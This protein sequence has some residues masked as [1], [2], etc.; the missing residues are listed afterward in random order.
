MHVYKLNKPLLSLPPEHPARQFLEAFVECRRNCAGRELD[1]IDQA[2]FSTT[3]GRNYQFSSFIYANISFDVELDGW[4]GATPQMT[5]NER[6]TLGEIAHMRTLVH[7]CL[8][9]ADADHNAPVVD[10]CDQLLHM[11]DL[12]QH[13]IEY[14]QQQPK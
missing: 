7:E 14:R 13:C 1:G 11:F 2:W 6:H 12:W 10:M 4:L 9:A 3:D 5:E 8:D